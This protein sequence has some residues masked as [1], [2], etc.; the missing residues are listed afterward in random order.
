[1]CDDRDQAHREASW[2]EAW[3]LAANDLG[4]DPDDE[5]PGVLDLIW[6][7]TEKLMK[8]WGIPLPKS[9]SGGEAA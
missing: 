3:R 2:S 9:V 4:L 5:D 6:D 7:E 1:M 8:N